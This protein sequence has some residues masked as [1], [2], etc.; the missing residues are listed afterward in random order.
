V[1]TNV[2]RILAHFSYAVKS[3]IYI[4]VAIYKTYEVVCLNYLYKDIY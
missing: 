2:K 3:F 1:N 4:L